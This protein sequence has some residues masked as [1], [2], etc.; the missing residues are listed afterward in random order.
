MFG[1]FLIR[2]FILFDCR[3]I[4]FDG[5]LPLDSSR[6][7]M[8]EL[9]GV[10]ELFEWRPLFVGVAGGTGQLPVGLS[11]ALCGC[12]AGFYCRWSGVCIRFGVW[13]F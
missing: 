6:L 11:L 8:A 3:L 1:L 9:F 5:L 4:E 12:L 10:G 2:L 13:D 7:P